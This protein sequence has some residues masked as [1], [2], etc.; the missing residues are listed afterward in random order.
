MKLGAEHLAQY[1]KDGFLVIENWFP[2]E[3][4]LAI[5]GAMH[6]WVPPR[7]S[8]KPKSLPKN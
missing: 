2:E 1:E 5:L 6:Q 4:R 8:K 7:P 3:Q